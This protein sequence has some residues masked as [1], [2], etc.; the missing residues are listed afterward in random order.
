MGNVIDF[1]DYLDKVKEDG[2]YSGE[3]EI[4]AITKIFN[5]SIYIFEIKENNNSYKLLYKNIA[6]NIFMPYCLILLHLYI[7]NNKKAE[8]FEM[9][10]INPSTFDFYLIKL[11]EENIESNADFKNEYPIMNDLNKN[12][13]ADINLNNNYK[14][15][16]NNNKSK[17]KEFKE[18]KNESLMDLEIGQ[19]N[20]LECN[21]MELSQYKEKINETLSYQ[22]NENID[23]KGNYN[24]I[25][26]IKNY[27]EN[28]SN[29][30]II[31]DEF[32]Q[33]HI[34]IKNII[35]DKKQLE[36]DKLQKILNIAK[37]IKYPINNVYY[38]GNSYYSDKYY[39]LLSKVICSKI[40]IYPDYITFESDEV[41]LENKKRN[42]RKSVLNYDLNENYYLCFKHK[43]NQL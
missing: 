16:S 22:D 9:L 25:M 29:L 32:E 2:N 18:V 33:E 14:K 4:S 30:R 40:R 3:L 7:N 15:S 41:L 13:Q 6:E 39:Y 37:K 11:L 43:K 1:E 36:S 28:N 38:N 17:Q 31:I 24:N 21:I 19:T 23:S 42:F 20:Q 12:S 34:Q 8:H 35:N 26:N 10:K 27:K 5:I